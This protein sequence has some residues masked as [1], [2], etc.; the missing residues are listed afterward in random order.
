M[1]HLPGE[2]HNVSLRL[3]RRLMHFLLML[4]PH[5]CVLLRVLYTLAV[6][7]YIV[8][9]F[10]W[11][12]AFNYNVIYDV[13]HDDVSR[14]LDLVNF[15]ALIVGHSIVAQELLWR[16]HSDRLE[17]QLQ[18]IRFLLR[19]QFGHHVNLKRIE[20]YCNVIYRIITFRVTVLLLIT[21]YNCLTTNTSHLLVC[22]LYS[23]MVLTLRC[24]EFSLYSV[25]VLALYREL[26][27][28]GLD[29]VS[30]L[31]GFSSDSDSGFH[32]QV[33][34]IAILQQLHQAL[35]KTQ[36]DI[37]ANFER[38]LIVVTMKCFVDTSVMPYWVYLNRTRLGTLAMQ[39]CRHTKKN[40]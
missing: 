36:L 11:R 12:F 3:L 34:C 1:W 13:V 37:E 32:H 7:S 4:P 39:I 40:F 38:S 23:E 15:I 9:I 5:P 28:A 27:E 17:Q 22:H 6:L 33:G 2:L 8:C 10:E 29:I 21:I 25:L 24:V 19:V 20:S 18:H 26:H 30:K 16:D 31:D 14:V 35:W